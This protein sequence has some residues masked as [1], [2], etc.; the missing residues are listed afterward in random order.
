[1]AVSVFPVPS[2]VVDVNAPPGAV[3]KVASFA[4]NANASGEFTLPSAGNYA[5]RYV[6]GDS[7]VG[8]SV[9]NVSIKAMSEIAESGQWTYF[10]VHDSA[11]RV[12]VGAPFF[13]S[14]LQEQTD[15]TI[16]FGSGQQE[17]SYQ[18]TAPFN[19]NAIIF[20]PFLN[21]F[22]AAG[23]SGNLA[24]SPDGF[25]WTSRTSG[26]SSNLWGFAFSSNTVVVFGDNG[27]I[28]SSTNGTSWTAR[29]SGTTASFYDGIFANGSFLLV[30]AGGWSVRSSDGSTWALNAAASGGSTMRHIA[31]YRGIWIATNETSF[32]TGARVYF[33]SNLGIG[34]TVATLPVRG[35][36]DPSSVRTTGVTTTSSG[37]IVSTNLGHLYESSTGFEWSPSWVTFPSGI[38]SSARNF[39][40]QLVL[41]LESTTLF[42]KQAGRPRTFIRLTCPRHSNWGAEFYPCDS[43]EGPVST[44]RLYSMSQNRNTVMM[45]DRRPISGVVE[46]YR[47]AD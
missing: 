6:G 13:S 36:G 5:V 17:I 28:S 8:V 10:K 14:G 18:A 19:L 33:T 9:G 40:G 35:Y 24:T 12:R 32:T 39:F 16:A 27:V 22:I 31:F 30:G 42:V 41:Q 2:N 34:W 47:M 45:Y 25:T 21:L 11:Q 4:I 15:Q 26:V 44:S 23:Q 1:M 20:V 43:T 46:I 38:Q 7:H 37:F 29:T 3:S